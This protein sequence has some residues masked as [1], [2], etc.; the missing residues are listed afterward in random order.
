MF[1]QRLSGKF[2]TKRG[3]AGNRQGGDDMRDMSSKPNN[4]NR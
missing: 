2:P 3:M 4:G 1:Y